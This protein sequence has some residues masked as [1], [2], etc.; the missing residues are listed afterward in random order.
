MVYVDHKTGE[1]K[2]SAEYSLVSHM[3]PVIINAIAQNSMTIAKAVSKETLLPADIIDRIMVEDYTPQQRAEILFK[4]LME[5][6]KKDAEIVYK[7]LAIL[8]TLGLN[9]PLTMT[10][11]GFLPLT[12]K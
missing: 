4:A 6:I 9:R 1:K 11:K 3:S 7:F 5:E 2:D 12:S 8:S 10:L